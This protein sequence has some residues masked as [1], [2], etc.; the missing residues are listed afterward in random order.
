MSRDGREGTCSIAASKYRRACL[1]VHRFLGRWLLLVP[2]F[3]LR[4]LVSDSLGPSIAAVE[5]NIG[6]MLL[7][8]ANVIDSLSTVSTGDASSCGGGSGACAAARDIF[9]ELG[10]GFCCAGGGACAG[11]ISTL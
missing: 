1:T 9:D 6:A 7:G 11:E 5:V 2:L 4:E 3:D 10:T 8:D